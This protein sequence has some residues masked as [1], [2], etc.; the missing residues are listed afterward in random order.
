MQMDLTTHALL[1]IRAGWRGTVSILLSSIILYIVAPLGMTAIIA[2]LLGLI[3]LSTGLIYV[4]MM[5]KI[6]RVVDVHDTS[7]RRLSPA[8]S[9]EGNN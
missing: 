4:E 6:W 3:G 9:N 5:Q 7:V 2:I 8:S 1:G